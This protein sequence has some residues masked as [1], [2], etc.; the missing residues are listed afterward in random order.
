MTRVVVLFVPVLLVAGVRGGDAKMD[1]KAMEGVWA[2]TV[3]EMDGKPAGDK[4]KALKFKVIVKDGG[5][6][7]FFG[8][9]LVS[10]GTLTLRPGKTLNEVDAAI[11]DGAKG[12][13]QLG[14]YEIKGDE[15]WIAWGEPGKARPVGL[16]TKDGEVLLHYVRM[17]EKK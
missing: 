14:V 10:R 15:M 8:D 4:E 7:A 12:A 3:V 9:R 11:S 5:F 1:L 6:S 13:K 2:A 16:K 17:T